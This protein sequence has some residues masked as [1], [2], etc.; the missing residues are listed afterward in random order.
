[1]IWKILQIIGITITSF[2]G[3]SYIGKVVSKEEIDSLELGVFL[4]LGI[5]LICLRP[6]FG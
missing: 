4:S 5:V 3:L 2:I 6:V 1:M